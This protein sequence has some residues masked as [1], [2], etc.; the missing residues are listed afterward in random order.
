MPVYGQGVSNYHANWRVGLA[1]E[2]LLRSASA[3]TRRPSVAGRIHCGFRVGS[4]RILTGGR[5]S[6][7]WFSV[8]NRVCLVAGAL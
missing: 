6:Q 5:V 1:P 2:A 3:L 7:S 4:P 8:P